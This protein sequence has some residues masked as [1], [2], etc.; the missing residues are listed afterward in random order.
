MPRSGFGGAVTWIPAAWRRWMTPFQLE[1][2]AKAPWTSTTVS[3]AWSVVAG[4]MTAPLLGG[5][6]LEDR[7]GERF[8][9]FL[10]KVVADAALDGPV[11]IGASELPGI[12]TGVRM[13]GAVG[14]ALQGD[15]RH[16]DHRPLGEP[17]LQLAV[18]GLAVGQPQ[19]PAVVVDH[20]L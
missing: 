1:A 11:R 4:G 2:S 13:G 5:G 9:G 8:G 19:P 12:G 7:V 17:L 18:L 14:V 3:G 15:G 6:D 20:D 10:G 16:P